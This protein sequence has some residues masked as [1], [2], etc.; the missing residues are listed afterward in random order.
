MHSATRALSTTGWSSPST[1]TSLHAVTRTCYLPRHRCITQCQSQRRMAR[2]DTATTSQPKSHQ[3]S[4]ALLAA[5][6]APR[7]YVA[8]LPKLER[9]PSQLPDLISIRGMTIAELASAR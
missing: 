3:Q 5:V 8:S 7:L 9:A 4:A 6:K 1:D 2:G